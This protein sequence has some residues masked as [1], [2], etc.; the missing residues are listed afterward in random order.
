[1][2]HPVKC[3]FVERTVKINVYELRTSFHHFVAEA[4][5]WECGGTV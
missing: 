3:A 1:M 2:S 4:D 5:E